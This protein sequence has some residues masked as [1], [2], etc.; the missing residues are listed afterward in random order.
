MTDLK[1]QINYAVVC[2]NEFARL[3][4]IPEK[5]AFQYLYQNK[6][7]EFIKENYDAEH[8]LSIYDAVQDMEIICR[9]NGGQY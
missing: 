8:T 6:G 5:L 2:I 3:H 4:N 7:I 9:N 1:K